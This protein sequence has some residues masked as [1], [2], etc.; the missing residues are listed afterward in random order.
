M[1]LSSLIEHNRK[2]DVSITFADAPAGTKVTYTMTRLNFELGDFLLRSYFTL[3]EHDRNRRQYLDKAD[4]YFNSMLIPCLWHLME[5]EQGRYHEEAFVPTWEWCRVHKKKTIALSVFYGWDGLDDC[6]PADADLNFI[7]PWVRCLNAEQLEED[8]KRRL[9]HIMTLTK[10][11]ISNYILIN[12]VLGKGSRLEPGDYYS[13]IL[14][15]KTL[16]PYFLLAGSSWLKAVSRRSRS[17]GA[18]S[19]NPDHGAVRGLLAGGLCKG[20]GRAHVVVLGGDP[21]GRARYLGDARLIQ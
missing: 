3:P 20:A 10:D 12:E 21:V 8:M 6:D 19:L 5:P 2:G 9:H 7:Q 4:K 15:F 14:G 11:K 17:R 18:A 16:E 13:N 1:N